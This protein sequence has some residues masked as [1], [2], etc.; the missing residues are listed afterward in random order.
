MLGF[1]DLQLRTS[2]QNLPISLSKNI[3]SKCHS[4]ITFF[5]FVCTLVL[6]MLHVK[7]IEWSF[8]KPSFISFADFSNLGRR[9]F[10]TGRS[11]QSLTP[12]TWPS[13]PTT[14]WKLD[15]NGTSQNRE[16]EK[17]LRVFG[18]INGHLKKNSI[19]GSRYPIRQTL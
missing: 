2:V 4:E 14:K 8:R 7:M 19:F 16:G 6:Y 17:D 11:W 18:F 13:S 5:K 1:F 10:A 15:F 3:N 9:F 12:A